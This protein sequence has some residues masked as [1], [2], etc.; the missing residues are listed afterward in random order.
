[1]IL[2]NLYGPPGA[3]KSTTRADV[4]RRL[5]T[6]GVNCEEV[7][8]FAKR[9]TWEKRDLTLKCQPYVFG[10][11]LRDIEILKGQV[12]VCITD[13]PILLSYFYGD[14]YC[15]YP[16]AFYNGIL[17]IHHTFNNMNY[18]IKRVKPYNPS[19]RYQN[20]QQSD[21]IAG[22]L[23]N[24]LDINHITYGNVNG[25]ETAAILIFENIM[26]KLNDRT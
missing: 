18:L 23:E 25:D 16:R 7:P 22:E 3:G 2:C 12:D 6:A 9:L 21:E 26:R 13:S 17:A 8:E 11:Q 4:F 19:G 1:M 20:E 5:K 15:D 10:K 14:K 24:M